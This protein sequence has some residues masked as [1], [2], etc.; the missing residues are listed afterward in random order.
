MKTLLKS[1]LMI[2]LLA[3]VAI[4]W[5]TWRNDKVRRDTRQAV[6][7]VKGAVNE[8]LIKNAER[9][10]ERLRAVQRTA[11]TNRETRQ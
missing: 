8:E 6:S 2:A 3:L 7:S 4:G 10:A 5:M 9:L 11:E 1:V